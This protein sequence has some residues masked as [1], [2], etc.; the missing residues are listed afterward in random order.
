MCP[1]AN[2]LINAA[3]KIAKERKSSVLA[4]NAV[5][6]RIDSLTSIVALTAILGSNIFSNISWLDPVGGLLVSIMVIRAG[7]GNTGNA[8]LEIADVSIDEEVKHNVGRAAKEALTAN[9]I[10]D[11]V[12]GQGTPHR[13]NFTIGQVSGIKAGQSYLVEVDV[14]VPEDVTIKETRPIEKLVRER[15]GANV[16]G[17]RRVKVSFHAATESPNFVDDF[18]GPMKSSVGGQISKEAHNHHTHTHSE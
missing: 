17:V 9:P 15:V 1:E 2:V 5:H 4:S 18:V 8:L 16:R 10:N 7:W 3:I 12:S 13:E 11:A 14:K 6:H